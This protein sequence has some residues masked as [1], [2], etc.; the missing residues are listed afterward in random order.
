[1]IWAEDKLPNGIAT[2]T[3]CPTAYEF[4]VETSTV[5]SGLIRTDTEPTPTLTTGPVAI[6][7][8]GRRGMMDDGVIGMTAPM[9]DAGLGLR[10]TMRRGFYIS[11]PGFQ[12]KPARGKN[13]LVGHC[14][15]NNRECSIADNA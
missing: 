10:Q 9:L 14:A 11:L 3:I 15:V 8:T 1:M 2:D 6:S 12:I 5:R 7:G 13:S 4:C